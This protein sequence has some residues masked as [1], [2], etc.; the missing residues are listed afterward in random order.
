[1]VGIVH[2]NKL[3]IFRPLSK[4]YKVFDINHVSS[5]T[6][7]FAKMPS[8]KNVSMGRRMLT[9]THTHT[10]KHAQI[11]IYRNKNVDT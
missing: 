4:Y 10:A 3:Q 11:N 9:H 7:F 6:V 8:N 1:M 2:R 5:F